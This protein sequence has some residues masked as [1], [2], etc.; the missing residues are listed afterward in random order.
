MKIGYARVSTIDQ[1]LDL[2]LEALQKAGC[3]PEYI[4]KEHISAVKADRPELDNCLK[5][6]R[7]GDTLVIWRLDRLGRSLK[8]LVAIVNDLESKGIHLHSIK[9]NI[10]LST[11]TG[12]LQFNIFASFAQFERD[13]ISERTL[14]GLEVARAKGRKGGRQFKL[15]DKDQARVKQMMQDRDI[16]VNDIT[17]R[18]DISRST[19]YKIARNEYK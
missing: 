13:L 17:K 12:K 15:S 19:A 3:E 1:N 11:S 14:A 10:D 7:A 4:Y 2:Q 9:E 5:S 6:L 8:D 18:F 16:S